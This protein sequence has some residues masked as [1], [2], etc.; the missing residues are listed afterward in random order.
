MAL[1]WYAALTK[2]RAEYAAQERL[3]GAGIEVFLPC[4][5]TPHPR[6]GHSDTPLFPG[7]LFLRYN[8]EE[9]GLQQLRKLPQLV[10]MVAFDGVAAVVPDRVM[11]DLAQRVESLNTFGGV[12]TRY[13]TG[14]TVRVSLGPLESL[15]EV[16]TEAQSPQARVRVLL[17]FLG[18]RVEAEVPWH[19]VQ[20]VGF[21][22]LNGGRN[23]RPHRR[24]RGRGRWIRG[25]GPRTDAGPLATPGVLHSGVLRRS[26]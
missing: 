17:E 23:A 15:A 6:F 5:K 26:D 7:Y 12:W 18:R 24:T 1:L 16:V 20:P 10:G 25:H 11:A 4:A 8:L 3:R 22:V 13:R 2:P 21:G 9:G 19:H 14:E